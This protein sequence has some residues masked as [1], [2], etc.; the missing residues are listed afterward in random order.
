MHEFQYE[1]RQRQTTS[2]GT[3]IY[4]TGIL[5]LTYGLL[6]YILATFVNQK[7]I[8]VTCSSL[9]HGNEKK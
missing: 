1:S 5:A 7:T 4:E 9:E 2:L 6:T 3:Y 8:F